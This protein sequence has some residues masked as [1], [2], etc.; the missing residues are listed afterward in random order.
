M[1]AGHRT[2]LLDFFRRGDV[3][4]DI[5]MLAAQGALA[6]RAHEQLALLV[7][8][9]NDPDPD[10]AAAAESTLGMI[11][12]AS[13]AAFIGRSEVSTEVRA[14][15]AARGIEPDA[16]D[17][18]PDDAPLVDTAT[19]D[20]PP[21]VVAAAA[22]APKEDDATALQRIASLKVAQRIALAMKGS[23]EERAILIRDP[24]KIV[25]VAVLSSPK[26]NDSEVESIAKMSSI[27]DEIL[28]LIAHT[29]A[30]IKSYPVVLALTKNPKTPLG[31]S[32]NLLS[33]L[34]ER[35][36]RMLSTDRNIPDVLRI[37]ARKK[38]VLD[39]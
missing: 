13:L 15:F 5:R 9:V 37:T 33:R 31:V 35:D 14:F 6:P 21:V 23:R 25:G 30:W 4:R 20:L 16:L 11:P 39:K 36:L 24:N 17:A 10:V 8:L 1:E 34:N 27:S 12:R 32:M 3:A 7:L 18:P 19:A 38:I 22:D 28:R 26:M 2:H 29:R